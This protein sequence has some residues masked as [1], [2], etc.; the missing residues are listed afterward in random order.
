MLIEL[1]ASGFQSDDGRDVQLLVN[2]QENTETVT[3]EL[4]QGIQR[5][6]VISDASGTQKK[7]AVVD[8]R[9]TLDVPA[10]NVLMIEF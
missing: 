6:S 2:W 4:P 8:Q 3:V 5:V 1:D 7:M 10:L 9:I